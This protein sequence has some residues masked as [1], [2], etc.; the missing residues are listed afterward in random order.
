MLFGGANPANIEMKI[1]A[2]QTMQP[3]I[4]VPVSIEIWNGGEK[5][6][7]NGRVS[8]TLPEHMAFVGSP[9]SKKRDS[10]DTGDC[11]PGSLT[12]KSFEIIPLGEPQRAV[13]LKGSFDYTIPDD[14]NAYALTGEGKSIIESPALTIALETPDQ[15]TQGDLLSY[16][17][18]LE[19]T[20]DARMQNVQGIIAPI[21][22][23][24]ITTSDPAPVG[25]SSTWRFGSLGA[26]EKKQ[27][28]VTGSA[29]APESSS[30]VMHGEAHAS[31]DG[32]DYLIA[33]AEKTI[34]TTAS[35]LKIQVEEQRNTSAAH[36]GDTLTYLIRY[37]NT[38]KSRIENLS[39]T[40]ELMHPLFTLAQIRTDGVVD[41]ISR[42]IRFT[43]ATTPE[44]AQILPGSG[45]TIQ[46]VVPL[47]KEYPKGEKNIT[48]KVQVI[49]ESPTIPQ[50]GQKPIRA[51]GSRDTLLGGRVTLQAIGLFRD[52]ASGIVNAGPFPPKANT[53][54]EY[55]I[56]WKIVNE[57]TD[58]KNVTVRAKLRPGTK[59]IGTPTANIP[60]VP[61]FNAVSGDLTW[62]IGTIPA[63]RG[64]A[65]A[66]LEAIIHIQNTPS[67]TDIGGDVELIS[68]SVLSAQDDFT[69]QD[70]QST[71][72][73]ITTRLPDDP[74]MK[75]A[76][77]RVQP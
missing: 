75:D 22:G 30:I 39:L 56:H 48:L 62:Q 7:K 68:D 34:Q 42:T 60:T 64:T 73:R 36:P 58:A 9:E 6:L 27:I 14:K 24:Q 72:L 32:E 4:P 59:V 55:T 20:S 44:L 52:A 47:G 37:T 76:E 5:T 21:P 8:L 13:T 2:P 18:T 10:L 57:A 71:A 50:G 17:I 1:V 23:F 26:H 3:G 25:G 63:N 67:I 46:V 65:T 28:R 16:T 19:N 74:S 38:S 31:F 66:P 15:V 35:P 61:E 69:G 33:D 45:G 29:D 43:P 49:G 40:A 11:A 41:S 70:V 54:T 53:P 12:K 51:T 77:T